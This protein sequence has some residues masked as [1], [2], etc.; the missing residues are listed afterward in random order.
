LPPSI[1]GMRGFVDCFCHTA[2][3]DAEVII[4]WEEEGS[5]YKSID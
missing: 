3:W 5:M 2:R 1:P 4:G